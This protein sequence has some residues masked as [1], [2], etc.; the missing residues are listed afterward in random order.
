MNEDELNALEIADR[1]F[2]AL[3][4]GYLE[5]AQELALQLEKLHFSAYFEI[6][7]LIYLQ[8]DQPE[9]AVEILREGVD[10]AAA[11]WPLW[12]LLGNCLSDNGEF[13]EALDCYTRGLEI[14]IDEDARASLQFNQATALS[15]AGKHEEAL[16]L[17]DGISEEV[18]QNHI[19]LWW[20]VE[21]LRLRILSSLGECDQ[22]LERAERLEAEIQDEES[23]DFQSLSVFWEQSGVAL[24]ECGSIERAHHYAL[25]ALEEDRTNKE[26]LRLLRDTSPNLPEASRYFQV[27]LKGDFVDEDDEEMG[28][29]TSFSV[30][31]RV[32]EEAEQ[33]A[34]QMEA[35]RW[36][37][38]P[39]VLECEF[40]GE[41]E[42]Q[43]IGVFDVGPYN[44]YPL[45]AEDEDEDEAQS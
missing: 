26:A 22:V 4:E 28:F 35:P 20:R 31:A 12:Q 42:L 37:I 17:V 36:E 45:H 14:D 43:S 41:C 21:A 29:I 8:Q 40:E 34:L 25:K 19:S 32:A 2:E 18:L 1:A 33:L 7:A 15:R 10:K 23:D 6:Q 3:N 13:Q 11:A 39:H 38:P 5:T 16:I 44:C 27:L 9:A 24:K 30:V